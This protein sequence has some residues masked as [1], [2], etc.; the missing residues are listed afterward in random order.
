MNYFEE[1]GRPILAE[2]SVEAQVEQED[3]LNALYVAINILDDINRLIVVLWLE[4]LTEREIA[5]IIKKGQTFVHYHM[6]KIIIPFLRER[7]EKFR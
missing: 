3:L 6:T 2:V 7:L 4:G 5:K 1:I